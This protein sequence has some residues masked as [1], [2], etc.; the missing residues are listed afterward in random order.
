[1]D[2]GITTFIISFGR[3]GT[4]RAVGLFGKEVIPAFR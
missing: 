3:K 2:L 1:V 4:E